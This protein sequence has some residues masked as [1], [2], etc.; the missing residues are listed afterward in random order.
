MTKWIEVV[1]LDHIPVLGSRL[2]KTRTKSIA[3]FRST[4]NQVFAINDA[5]PHKKGPL[6]QGIMHGTTVTCP[7]HNWKLNLASGEV[8]APDQGCANTY[9]VKI[10]EGK[11]YLQ[12]DPE[13]FKDA[14]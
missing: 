10:V 4:D 14:E 6:S 7:L 3:V 13:S 11:V 1:E 5:C 12:L 8:L 2:I 9:P